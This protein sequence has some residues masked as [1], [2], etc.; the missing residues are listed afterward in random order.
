MG[1][2][3]RKGWLHNQLG[4]HYL[5]RYAWPEQMISAPPDKDTEIIVVIPCYDEPN[6]LNA[7]ESLEHC[8]HPDCGVEIIVVIN[9]ADLENQQIK[10]NNY[11]TAIQLEQWLK[12]PH[13]FKYYLIRAFDL[14]AKKAGVGLA[15]KI[16]MDEA[17]R[18]FE[19]LNQ[20]EGII[21]CYDAD[22]TCTINYL[23]EIHKTYRQSPDTNAA[24]IY[25]EHNINKI[26]EPEIKEAITNYE[27]HLRYYV[28][29]LKFAKFPFAFHTVGS[30]ITVRSDVYQ[31][32]GGMNS[33]KAGE[34]FY[35]LQRIFP[36]GNVKNINTATIFPSPRPSDRVPFG[37]GRAVGDMIKTNSKIFYTYHPQ[38]FMDFK[39]FNIKLSSF[40]ESNSIEKIINVLPESVRGYLEEVEFVSQIE[41]LKNNFKSQKK[42][43]QAIQNWFNGFKALKFVH[44]ARDHYYPNVEI[45][46]AANWILKERRG[47]EATE[48]LDALSEMRKLDKSE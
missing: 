4:N 31:K 3:K 41:K 2:G 11:H 1:N 7:L 28:Q 35:F 26:T 42:F 12:Q 17:V 13:Q 46:K 24:L 23:V 43:D 30:C 10:N 8:T 14:P 25:F 34:D 15:R 45:K 18:R 39:K 44:F 19:E 36:L 6:I 38:I 40:W 32:Q 20:H 37:T 22:C 47:I 9:H 27:L 16:G 48:L 29:A 33:R 5:N 21:V